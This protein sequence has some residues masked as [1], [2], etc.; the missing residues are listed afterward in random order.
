M[1]ASRPDDNMRASVGL[2]VK[3]GSQG[4]S[5]AWSQYFLSI[6][7]ALPCSLSQAPRNKAINIVASQLSSSLPSIVMTGCRTD[8]TK[9]TEEGGLVESAL[10]SPQ[11]STLGERSRKRNQRKNTHSDLIWLLW[12]QGLPRQHRD[13]PVFLPG[14]LAPLPQR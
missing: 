10:L 2:T 9:P 7:S 11:K 6:R 14:P 13:T 12:V 3:P 4:S 5:D 1:P 8:S